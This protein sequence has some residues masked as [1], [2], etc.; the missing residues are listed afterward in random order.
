MFG[1]NNLS[2]DIVIQE[3]NY[4]KATPSS[5]YNT[6]IKKTHDFP[7][8]IDYLP[9]G[10]IVRKIGIMAKEDLSMKDREKHI[11]LPMKNLMNL[12]KGQAV[13]FIN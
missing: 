8:Y 9:Q 1:K 5:R 6:I 10:A 7:D 11:F 13:L 2:Y 3:I 4:L 12:W